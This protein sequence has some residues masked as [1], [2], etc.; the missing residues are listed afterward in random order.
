MRHIA[1]LPYARQA[2][3]V[4][5]DLSAAYTIR[6]KLSISKIDDGSVQ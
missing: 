3:G 2:D 4:V 1:P 6:E 5:H